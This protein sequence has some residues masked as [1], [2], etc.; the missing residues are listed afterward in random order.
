MQ[1]DTLT[2]AAISLDQIELT[3]AGK[4]IVESTQLQFLAGQH[5]ALLGPNGAG[6]SSLIRLIGGE[7]QAKSG[8]VAIHGRAQQDWSLPALSRHM[9]ILPQRSQL[10]FHFSVSEVVG[11]GLL[12][13]TLSLKQQRQL[14]RERLQVV[15][16]WQLRER[17]YP[18]L[19]GGE[20]QRVHYA[21]VT[22]QLASVPESK[23]I[24]LLDEATSSLDLSHRQMLMED[25]NQLASQGGCV[26]SVVHDLNL[27]A[28]YCQRLVLLAPPK[29]I[30]DGSAKQV[31]S[32]ENIAKAF[33][34]PA[35]IIEHSDSQQP[36]VL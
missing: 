32:K 4:T 13:S 3:M 34:Y 28:R 2:N 29:V 8:S 31:L 27:A 9:A 20:Q 11:L 21:R 22:A 26:V 1:R 36:I 17:S 15:D 18:Q 14:I 10:N 30:A 19:S 5:C 12:H 24:L 16:M 6:K 35:T 25:A 33:D 7:L 23:R